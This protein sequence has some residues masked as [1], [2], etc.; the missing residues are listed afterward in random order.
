M[1]SIASLWMPIVVS[2][3]L[4]FVV[5]SLAHM[6]FTYH[7]RDYRQLPNEDETLDFLRRLGLARGYYFFPYCG[8]SKEMGSPEMLKKHTEGP[9]GTLTVMPSGPPA[10]GKFLGQWLGFLLVVGIFVAYVVGRSHPAGTAFL[11]IFRFAG[12][13]SFMAYGLGNVVD[14]I[15]KG[16]PW[17]NTCRAVADG[18]VYSLVTGGAFGWL[19]PH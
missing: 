18:L 9:V 5:S 11:T 3:V 17:A 2:T 7:R 12:A 14:S 4:V 6:V 10:M 16:Q 8:S 1:T 15:W 19:W 13:T